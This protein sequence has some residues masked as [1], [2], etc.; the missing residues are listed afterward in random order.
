MTA[1]S[2]DQTIGSTRKWELLA[3]SACRVAASELAEAGVSARSWPLSQRNEPSDLA[4]RLHRYRKRWWS[5]GVG[6]PPER[7]VGLVGC[8][9][10]ERWW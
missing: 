7:P 10:S 1:G 6:A 3:A 5:E 2:V 4:A 8:W 9:P